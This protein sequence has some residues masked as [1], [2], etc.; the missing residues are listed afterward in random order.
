MFVVWIWS[1]NQSTLDFEL[2]LMDVGEDHQVCKNGNDCE[3]RISQN[4]RRDVKSGH[5]GTLRKFIKCRRVAND[6]KSHDIAE[7]F[8]CVRS[9]LMQFGRDFGN[10]FNLINHFGQ[11]EDR[12][13]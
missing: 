4:T 13:T 5:F 11:G 6:R 2:L 1:L 3:L 10:V 12:V 8:E 7:E 9:T